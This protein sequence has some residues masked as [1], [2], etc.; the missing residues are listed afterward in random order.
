MVNGQIA[1]TRGWPPYVIAVPAEWRA[2]ANDVEVQVANT[3]A[4]LWEKRRNMHDQPPYRNFPLH[5]PRPRSA[6]LALGGIRILD[7]TRY[8]AGPWCTQTLA[9]MGAE[10][11]KIEAV[12]TGDETRTY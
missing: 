6:P 2:G 10:V 1:A 8:L 3:A 7:F 4:N 12:G 5:I 9:D 11:I